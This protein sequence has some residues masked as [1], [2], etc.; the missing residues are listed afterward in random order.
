VLFTV[1]T[2]VLDTSI[3]TGPGAISNSSA[4]TFSFGSNKSPV[5][6]ECKLDNG[7]FTSCSNPATFSG[8]ND[9]LHQLQVRAVFGAFTDATPA[10]ATWTVD[11][12]APLPPDIVNPANG[13]SVST[14]MVTVT[15]TA[16]P[17]ST[18]T[19][20]VDSGIA[21][22]VLSN[23]AGQFSL[24]LA[25]TLGQG[26]HTVS[27]IATDAAGNQSAPSMTNTFRI[28]TQLP[29]TPSI[30]M[31]I[32]N[33]V[34]RQPLPA[35]SGTGEAGTTVTVSA[36]GMPI[37]SAGVT[38][39]GIWSLLPA[40]PLADGAY[41]L[42]ATAADGAGNVSMASNVV[43]IVIDTTAPAMPVVVSPANGSS[44]NNATPTVAGTSEPFASVGVTLDGIAIGTAMANAQGDFFLQLTAALP[45][46]MHSVFAL[47]ADAAGNVSAPSLT[48]TFVI[49]L[50]APAPPT[51]S[52]PADGSTVNTGM[53]ALA[54]TAEPLCTVQLSLDGASVPNASADALGNFARSPLS[55]Q[56]LGAGEHVLLAVCVDAAGNRSGAARSTFT[57]NLPDGGTEPTP[58]GGVAGDG[59]VSIDG[60]TNPL[61]DAGPVDAGQPKDAGVKPEEPPVV[62]NDLSL[63]G[64]GCGCSQT[65][66]SQALLGLMLG[67]WWQRR[68][69]SVQ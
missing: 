39:S 8:L 14:N 42:V 45:E 21:G 61:V 44:L 51:I 69:K 33:S 5:T 25:S 31:P 60:G 68:R 1:D 17:G 37:A 27:A 24:P 63:Q 3:L 47:A 9:A 4:A 12:V 66:G 28:D 19:V 67:I 2:A 30:D 36:N 18:V 11:T 64:G 38:A 15:G 29:A 32:T 7:A 22:T 56:A 40:Q 6:Y 43:R 50:T 57:V 34:F 16:E 23:A 65:T 49:D 48:N 58:D 52:T 54:G 26:N 62:P 59:G 13:S 35:I 20:I 53:P 10:T 41:A 46:G 55:P